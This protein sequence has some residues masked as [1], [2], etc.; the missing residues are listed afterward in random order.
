MDVVTQALASVTLSRAAFA[1]TTR[2]ATPILLATA[3]APDLDLLSSFGGAVAYLRFH[4]S[5]LHSLPA[6]LIIAFVI[7][8]GAYFADRRFTGS[9]AAEPLG[10]VCAF[11]ICLL[12]VAFHDVLDLVDSGGVQL[13]WPFHTKWYAWNLTANLDPWILAV[14]VA[15]LLLRELFR[16]KNSRAGS[17]GRLLRSRLSP[18]TSSG[19]ARSAHAPWIFLSL[20]AIAALFQSLQTLFPL[21]CRH[22]TGEGWWPQTTQLSNWK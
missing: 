8:I 15:G 5:L 6:A 16:R 10:F 13:F 7:A 11:G 3:L 1:R 12:G 20:E 22:S 4:R 9:T 19:A 2:L 14:L 17:A 18:C 21:R